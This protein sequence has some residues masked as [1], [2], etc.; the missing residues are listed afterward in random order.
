MTH[1]C[2]LHIK[3]A[4]GCLN[5]YCC[6]IVFINDFVDLPRTILIEDLYGYKRVPSIR[7]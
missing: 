5:Q 7:L 1:M 6:I 3:I 2:H 4:S